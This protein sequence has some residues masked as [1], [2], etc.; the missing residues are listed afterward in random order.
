MK[1]KT[2]LKKCPLCGS[3][4]KLI[5]TPD[6]LQTRFVV[7]CEGCCNIFP[8]DTVEEAVEAWN[9]RVPMVVFDEY[10]VWG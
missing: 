3:R 2:E 6:K 8:K 10:E 1:I 4:P 7:V 9:K 5:A